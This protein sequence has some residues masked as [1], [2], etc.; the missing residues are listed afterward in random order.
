V[1]TIYDVAERAGV[2]ASTVSRVLNDV[3]RVDATLA[4]RVREAATELSYQRNVVA[5]NLRRQTSSLWAVLISDVENP[6]FTSLVRGVEDVALDVGFSVVLCNSDEKADKED[7]Y[8]SAVLGEKM[9]GVL[10][11][12]ARQSTAVDRLVAADV[13]VVVLDRAVAATDSGLADGVLVDNESGARR[14]TSHLVEAGYRRIA[15]ITGPAALSTA[16]ARLRGY[17]AALWEAGLEADEGLVRRADFREAGGSAAM[18]SMLDA[19]DPPDAVFV[20]N[21]LMTVGAI[22]VIA[23]RG[24]DVP[25]EL[26][27]V[28]FDEVPWAGLVRPS[29]TTVAQPTYEIGKVAAQLL[30][31]RIRG[32]RAEAAHRTLSTELRVRSSSAGPRTRAVS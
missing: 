27:V 14:A 2:S 6:F 20:A 21:N 28:G 24:I 1:V 5:R 25:A 13:P 15:C 26:G 18:S 8:V 12:P 22:E 11:S 9:A 32:E 4:E 16:S 17:K 31:E 10:V 7:S 30:V 3:G 19:P 29:L 23:Q